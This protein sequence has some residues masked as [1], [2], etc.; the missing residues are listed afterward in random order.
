VARAS[1]LT[2]SAVSQ[3]L[4]LLERELDTTLFER[5]GRRLRLTEAARR[6]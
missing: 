5:Q 3:Q 4:A 2:P 6:L 1:S